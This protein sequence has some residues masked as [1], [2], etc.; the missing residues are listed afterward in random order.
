ML[1]KG[2]KLTGKCMFSK[3]ITSLIIN[4]NKDKVKR[5]K[6]NVMH[7]F[8]IALMH[9]DEKDL[10]IRNLKHQLPEDSVYKHI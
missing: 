7:Q 6:I 1:N 3:D 5:T 2:A 4:L 9:L 8:R 10:T